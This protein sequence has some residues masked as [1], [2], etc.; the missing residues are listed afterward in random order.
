MKILGS[1]LVLAASSAANYVCP[2]AP[3]MNDSTALEYGHQIQRLL[4]QYYHSVPVNVSFFSSLPEGQT[5]ASNGMTLAENTLTNV[6]GLE[7]QAALALRAISDEISTIKGASMPN[8][9]DVMLPAVLNA[10][11][12]LM[13]AFNIEA[14]LCGAFI[15]LGDYFQ[16]PTL[17][18]LSARI[19]AEHGI[20]AS[21]LRSMMQPV[22][23]MPNSTMLTPAF[24]PDEVLSTGTE[25]GQLGGFLRHCNISVPQAPCGG[26]VSFGPLLSNLTGQSS[27]PA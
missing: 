10:S 12:H 17:N 3:S 20:H 13:N 5:T 26:M 24:R 7:K 8:M 14:S 27:K 18:S 1:L 15:G 23:F 6:Q 19:A 21:A 4:V 11:A 22:G 16:S 25:V 9:C 2:A